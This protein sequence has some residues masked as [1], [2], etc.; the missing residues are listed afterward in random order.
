[1]KC[2]VTWKTKVSQLTKDELVQKA[3]GQHIYESFVLAK[4]KE[5]E[6]YS[7]MVYQWE[8]DEYLEKF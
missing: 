7:S 2:F 8:L 5:W 6:S 3:L 4:T 1:M